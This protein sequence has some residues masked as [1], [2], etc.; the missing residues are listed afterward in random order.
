MFGSQVF[1]PERD[2]I[3]G[4]IELIPTLSLKPLWGL[5]PFGYNTWFQTIVRLIQGKYTLHGVS[6]H[7]STY[8]PLWLHIDMHFLL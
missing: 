8:T 4:G 2:L 6:T 1:N 3:Q 5:I 7:H